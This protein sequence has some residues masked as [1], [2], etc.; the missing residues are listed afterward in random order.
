MLNANGVRSLGTNQPHANL[1][2]NMKPNA[3]I[4]MKSN[5]ENYTG[6]ISKSRRKLDRIVNGR[7]EEQCLMKKIQTLKLC[8]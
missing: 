5:R 7:S 3:W 1:T 4:I 6:D 8:G 2:R